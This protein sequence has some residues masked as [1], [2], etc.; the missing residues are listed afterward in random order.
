MT[1][2]RLTVLMTVYNGAAY[3]RPAIESILAQEM[4]DFRFLILDNASQD[5]SRAII[6][7]YRDARIDL[8]ELP[9]NVGQVRALNR[10]LD[11]VTTPL[12][13]RMD[14]D[15]ISM[16]G[17]FARQLAFLERHPEVGLCGGFVA[18]FGAGAGG[19]YRW[20]CRPDE[21]KTKLLFENCLSHGTVMLRQDWFNR[22]RLRYNETIGHSYDWDLWQ[23]AA[24]LFPLANLPRVLLRYRVHAGMESGKTAHLQRLAAETID[25]CA[26][27]RLGLQAHPLRPRHRDLAYE[28]LAVVD[29]DLVFIDEAGA[30]LAE[31]QRAND[32]AAVY[33]PRALRRFC[34]TRLVVA[35]SA[36]AGLGW[37]LLRRF[38]AWRLWSSVPARRSLRFLA[39]A[40]LAALGRRAPRQPG[41]AGAA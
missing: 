35:M 33:A 2:P 14:A 28:T 39:K 19:A 3:L 37:P 30:W 5:D 4:G 18:V 20:P 21:I 9:G 8:V 41:Q 32:R 36:N 11:L 31:L 13:A 24:M 16:P 6:R 23:R 17:R 27:G 10:G 12:L 7:G 40:T 1:A 22:H 38:A 29:R 26:L 25:A 15:D 34:A